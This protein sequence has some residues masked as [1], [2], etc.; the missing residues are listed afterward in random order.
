MC[1]TNSKYRY[2]HSARRLTS[3]LAAT[4]LVGAGAV[5]T[6][7]VA[8]A[9]E[10]SALSL[11]TFDAADIVEQ[12][13]ALPGGLTEAVERDLGISPEQWLA[14]AE[15]TKVATD[16]LAALKADG[17]GV[18]GASID[19]Q[20]VTVYVAAEA[21]VAAVEAVGASVEVGEPPR[22][23]YS[24][25]EIHP[26]QDLWGGQGY[27]ADLEAEGLGGACSFGFNGYDASGSPRALTAGHCAFAEDAGG[28]EHELDRVFYNDLDSPVEDGDYTFDTAGDQVGNFVAGENVFGDNHDAGLID[29]TLP[30]EE[31]PAEVS[32][33]GGGTGHPQSESITI[34]DS[35]VAVEGAEMCKSGS[36]SGWTCGDPADRGRRECRR[37]GRPRH[38]RRH[39]PAAR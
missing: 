23:D 39:L 35:I 29:I 37:T 20:D 34:Y 7:G 17:V 33:W 25:R 28:N 31:T 4:A 3:V 14:N 9:E 12:A 22:D 11:Q 27:L 24:D 38:H 5:A 10:E 13:A 32:T 26:A 30:D 18:A 6:A 8:Y 21:D 1:V 19:G 2:R 36:R 15:A 16:V